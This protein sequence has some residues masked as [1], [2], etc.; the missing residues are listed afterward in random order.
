MGNFDDGVRKLKEEAEK[1][2][3][4]YA[5]LRQKGMD[6]YVFSMTNDY[7]LALPD[8]VRAVY[9]KPR[10]LEGHVVLSNSDIEHI[11]ESFAKSD[12]SFVVEKAREEGVRMFSSLAS[13]NCFSSSSLEKVLRGNVALINIIDLD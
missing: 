3:Q 7:L 2:A 9:S 5:L 4:R 10:Y 11:Q 13:T 12:V 1:V 8:T 6:L